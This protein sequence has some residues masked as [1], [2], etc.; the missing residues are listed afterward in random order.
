MAQTLRRHIDTA[1][2]FRPTQSAI[3]FLSIFPG[4][5]GVVF[6]NCCVWAICRWRPRDRGVGRRSVLRRPRSP[7]APL[8]RE[9]IGSKTVPKIQKSPAN[10]ETADFASFRRV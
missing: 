8:R 9:L 1:I 2:Y 7:F 10:I 6:P 4:Q 3:D 5:S